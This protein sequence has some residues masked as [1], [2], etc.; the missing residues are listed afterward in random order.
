MWLDCRG[1]VGIE[2]QGNDAPAGSAADDAAQRL[3]FNGGTEHI[4]RAEFEEFDPA[5]AVKLHEDGNPG[6][7]HFGVHPLGNGA[8]PGRVGGHLD[9]KNASAFLDEK[10]SGLREIVRGVEAEIAGASAAHSFAARGS[11]PE[12]HAIHRLGGFVRIGMA[13]HGHRA[14]PWQVPGY[15]IARV[16]HDTA[17]PVSWIGDCRESCEYTGRAVWLV[18]VVTVKIHY[19]LMP[20]K[21]ILDALRQLDT[22]VVSNAIETFQLRLRNEGYTGPAIRALFPMKESMVGYAATCRFRTSGPPPKNHHYFDRTDWWNF[23]LAIPEPRVAVFEDVDA[24]PGCG[25]ILGEVHTRILMS[26]GVAG[27]VSNGSFRDLHAVEKLGFPLF[28]G[29][30]C[31]SHSYAHIVE[32]GQPVNVGGLHIRSG[33]L[34]HGD[35]HGVQIV[36]TNVAE[37]IPA[38]VARIQERE[39]RILALCDSDQFSLEQ[40]KE[41]VSSL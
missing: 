24:T 23:L 28:A 30:V 33:D 1:S 26:M 3:G 41:A 19:I 7:A 18:L 39:R 31:L 32:I 38:V 25:A 16:L 12:K 20:P 37:E 5:R 4:E 29:S 13:M 36:P 14:F 35:R 22:C 2:R 27:A 8:N 6:G 15:E 40:L 11:M 9:E 17:K 34:L 10:A 21:A